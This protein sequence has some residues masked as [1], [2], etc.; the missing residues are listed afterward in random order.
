MVATAPRNRNTESHLDPATIAYLRTAERMAR[1]RMRLRH[2]DDQ[3][4]PPSIGSI[5]PT[6]TRRI[7]DRCNR[8]EGVA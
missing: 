7:V 4:V 1:L 6:V 8:R 5:L 3:Y 2:P